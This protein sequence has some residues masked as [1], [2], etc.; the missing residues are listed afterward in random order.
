M[1]LI[2]LFAILLKAT[3]LSFS[4]F[5]SL[6]VLRD[7]LI[8][9]R[10]ALTDEQLNQAVS[11]ARVTPGPMGTYVVAVGYAVS[12]WQ[13]AAAGWAAMS[14]PALGVIPLL[15]LMRGRTHSARWQGAVEAVILASAALVLATT[16][17]LI[18]AAI[19]DVSTAVVASVALLTVLFTRVSTIWVILAGAGTT[20]LFG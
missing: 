19:V 2:V 10:H 1:G 14:A 18:P 6:P 17:T 8:V 7:E 3:L 12:G 20:W 9:N 5:G 4:G 15:M 13:G 11:V 16:V